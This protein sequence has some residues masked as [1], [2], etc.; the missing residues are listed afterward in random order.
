MERMGTFM[1][2]VH[3][4]V[5]YLWQY[6]ALRLWRVISW[7]GLSAASERPLV[8]VGERYEVIQMPCASNDV[9]RLQE[10]AFAVTARSPAMQQF[11]EDIFAQT[12]GS[13]R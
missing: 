1:E 8:P 4:D 13:A 11:F 2:D 3:C 9:I 12:E 5:T 7:G 10:S 6:S